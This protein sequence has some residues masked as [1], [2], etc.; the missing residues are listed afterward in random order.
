VALSTG[1]GGVGAAMGPLQ[2]QDRP[3]PDQGNVRY[4]VG[5]NQHGTPNA[6][7]IPV[8]SHFQPAGQ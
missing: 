3:L 4:V 7:Y 6:A 5:T 8:S 1:A 2:T